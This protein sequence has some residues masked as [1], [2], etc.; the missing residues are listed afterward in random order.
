MRWK[1]F[2][3]ILN[4]PAFPF[5][6]GGKRIAQNAPSA[7]SSKEPLPLISRPNHLRAELAAPLS[8]WAHPPYADSTAGQQLP[9]SRPSHTC[10]LVI[11]PAIFFPPQAP[12]S[13]PLRERASR[14]HEKTRRPHP[15]LLSWILPALSSKAR[16]ALA[17]EETVRKAHLTV[18]GAFRAGPSTARIWSSQALSFLSSRP[19]RSGR[20]ERTP[21][22]AR[23]L[24]DRGPY[25]NRNKL[26][27][28]HIEYPRLWGGQLCINTLL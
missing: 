7:R 18:E 10:T 14:V 11:P 16:S 24:W 12:R 9:T 6:P 1:P 20:K 2:L 22:P 15:A 3:S 26:T 19:L 28:R 17:S 8:A 25:I 4:R 13:P 21:T 5:A 23:R 27:H